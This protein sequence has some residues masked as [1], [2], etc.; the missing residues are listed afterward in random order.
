MQYCFA[1]IPTFYLQYQNLTILI[2]KK[3]FLLSLS[4]VIGLQSFAQQTINPSYTYQFASK[5]EEMEIAPGGIMVVGTGKGFSAIEAHKQG[6]IYEYTELGKIK[7]EEMEL[8]DGYPWVLL[9]EGGKFALKS[10]KV[11]LDYITGKPIF[12]SQKFGWVGPQ[13]FKFIPERGELILYG[14]HTKS[15]Y[16]L[17]IY[18]IQNQQEIAFYDLG[19]KKNGGGMV[20]WDQLKFDD[21]HA[22]IPTA[23]AVICINIKSKKIDWICKQLSNKIPGLN[24]FWDNES[25]ATYAYSTFL[26][27]PIY[28]I[29]N[30]NGQLGWKKPIKLAGGVKE[31]RKINGGLYVYAEEAKNFEINFYDTETGIKRWKKSFKDDGGISAKIF[32]ND[33]LI[34][35]TSA[36]EVNTLK[37][38]G[39]TVLKKPIEIG[40][41]YM[42]FELTDEGNLFYLTNFKMGI[43]NLKDGGF[44][45]NPVKFKKVELMRT[46]YDEKNKRFVVSTGNELF[47]VDKD[48]NINKIADIKFKE[49]ENPNKIE[50]RAGGILL[51][52]SQNAMLVDYNGTVKYS[53]YFKAPGIST[54]GKLLAGAVMAASMGVAAGN[55]AQAGMMAGSSPGL[56]KSDAQKRAES[57][58]SNAAGVAN[59]SVAIMTQRFK[60]TA[61]T[62]NHLYIL[63]KLDDGVGLVK[64]NKDTGKVDGEIILKDKKPVYKIDEDF[65]VFYFQKSDKEIIGY[66][67]R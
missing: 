32:T 9:H 24:F 66:D 11:L 53:A 6:V 26:K 36:G 2:I 3:S 38:D 25:N 44:V 46:A 10:K 31:L 17:A 35:G 47:F 64:L 61:A 51:S 57:N 48:G 33:A 34:Y 20:F 16:C 18:D 23:N 60:A 1:N 55:A 41:G 8:M 62:K 43:A 58:A 52:A 63:T 29:N 37:F 12:E 59:A 56:Y 28:K 49:D 54:A 45:K 27:S 19:D 14:S 15:W 42:V 50:F 40:A 67:M 65:G 21:M 4:L 22:F 13:G 30:S 7:P 5:I 39:T